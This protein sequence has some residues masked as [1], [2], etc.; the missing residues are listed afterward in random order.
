M[1]SLKISL[2]NL[3]DAKIEF[4]AGASLSYLS[5]KYK[6]SVPSLKARFLMLDKI[7]NSKVPALHTTQQIISNSIEDKL[8][9]V[10]EN[11]STKS[12]EIIEKADE[13][14][15]NELTDVSREIPAKDAAS[16]SDLYAK[17][18]GRLTGIEVDPDDGRDP[19]K[20]NRINV[21]INTTM[22]RFRKDVMG[23]EKKEKPHIVEAEVVDHNI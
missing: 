9:E 17:R 11:L 4:V 13:R 16:I 18:L 22:D 2:E 15:L 20:M 14:V 3:L 7:T 19:E 8:V 12:L 5:K 21:I 6:I 10:R 23:E 1:K